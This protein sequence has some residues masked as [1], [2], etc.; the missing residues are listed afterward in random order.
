VIRFSRR[1][2]GWLS[3]ATLLLAYASATAVWADGPSSPGLP[4]KPDAKAS[5]GSPSP[6]ASQSKTRT[7]GIVLY[8]N[9]E[10]LDVCGPAEMFGNV[11]RSLRIVMVAEEAGPVRSTQGIKVVADYGFADCPQLDLILVPGGS[12]TLNQLRNKA[13]LDWLKERSSRAELVTSVCSGA[14]VLAKAGLLDGRPATTNKQYY[15]VCT[16]PGPKVKWIKEARW[17]DDGAIVTS[18]GVSAGMDMAMHVIARLYGAD[19]AQ[20]IANGTEYVWNKD[21][22]TDPFARFAK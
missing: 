13:L 4:G 16:S 19:T 9:F 12:G 18:S 11:G 8:K 1:V 3:I 15:S 20:K 7:L 6:S 14:A 2:L 5:A 17:V 10:L 22:H 21:P